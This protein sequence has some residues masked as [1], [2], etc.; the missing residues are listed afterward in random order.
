MKFSRQVV[1]IFLLAALIVVSACGAKGTDSGP[2]STGNT[3][4]MSSKKIKIGI[5]QIVEHLSLDEARRGFVQALKDAGY[6]EGETL[7]IDFQNAQGDLSNAATITQKFAS[8]KKDLVLAIATPTAQAA[9]QNIKNKPIL[10]TAVTDPIGAGLVQSIEKPGANVTGTADLHPDAIS[11][12]ME[13]I[14]SNVKDIKAVG[15]I[16]NEGEQNTHINV[17]Q[18]VDALSKLGVEV[19]KAP[20]A[21]SSEVKQATESLAGK[22]QAIYVPSDNTVVSALATVISV[23]SDIKIPTFVADKDSVK[24]GGVA[25]YGFEYF[26][27][28]YST[29]KMA[30]EILKEG[31]KPA[32]L[33]VKYPETLDLA[34]NL[35]AAA[36]QGFDVTA[37]MKAEVKQENLFE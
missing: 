32:D 9:A 13:F 28:G 17:K 12:L 5:T 26:D 21:N 6:V 15:I 3:E 19:V 1:L 2:V 18:A 7:E 30:I 8:D 27:L 10:F 20:V 14:A 4:G 11:K 25:S 23:A 34:L 35:K 22:V 33:A 37:A 36:S 31:K 16:A 29:G 24:N